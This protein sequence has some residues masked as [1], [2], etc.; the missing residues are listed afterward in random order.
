[1]LVLFRLRALVLR[2][3]GIFGLDLARGAVLLVLRV[4]LLALRVL[5]R[6]LLRRQVQFE[7][8]FLLA[9][10]TDLIDQ[11]GG[12]KCLVGEDEARLL[13]REAGHRHAGNDDPAAV[14]K[15]EHDVDID[16]FGPE[17]RIGHAQHGLAVRAEL[18]DLQGADLFGVDAGMGWRKIG[19]AARHLRLRLSASI[20]TGVFRLSHN[21]AT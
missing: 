2:L 19:G 11:I 20:G 1:M 14:L 16:D 15:D 5:L 10:L 18:D 8:L 12:G 3:V 9:D 6:R 7:R 13:P 17:R 4:G 21:P